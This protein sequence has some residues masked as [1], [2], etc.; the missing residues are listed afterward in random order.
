MGEMAPTF[1]SELIRMVDTIKMFGNKLVNI[2]KVF[3]KS[4]K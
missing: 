3:I 2:I 4:V 1:I